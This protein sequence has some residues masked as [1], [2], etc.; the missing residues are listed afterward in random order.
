MNQFEGLGSIDNYVKVLIKKTTNQSG[1]IQPKEEAVEKA[2]WCNHSE[3]NQLVNCKEQAEIE[4]PLV[5]V[6]DEKDHVRILVQCHCR[7][8]Q[9]TFHPSSDGIIVCRTEC[10]KEK[11]GQETCKDVC[12][13]LS[14][15]TDELQIANM[16]F[17]VAKCNNNNTLEAMI[18]KLKK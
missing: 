18:P 5:D 15:R 12:S 1:T 4:D 11:G 8:Q 3:E 10:R 9:V 2:R 17:V 13:K 6:F 7:E 16:L 14:I